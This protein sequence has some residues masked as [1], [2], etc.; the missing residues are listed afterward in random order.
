MPLDIFTE[1]DNCQVCQQFEVKA[2]NLI[3][4]ANHVNSA[5]NQDDV[6]LFSISR[7]PR[8]RRLFTRL[9]DLT[10][11]YHEPNFDRDLK[12]AFYD[13]A[14]EML[15]CRSLLNS[16]HI[17]QPNTMQAGPDFET[18]KAYVECINA[19]PA[20]NY[21]PTPNATRPEDIMFEE[22]P[23]SDIQL[24]IT[25]AFITKSRVIKRYMDRGIINPSKPVVIALN[26]ARVHK[27]SWAD[28]E[29][30]SDNFVLRSLFGM[31]P[32]SMTFDPDNEEPKEF[33][34][35][36]Q[37]ELINRNN[38]VVP[39]DYFLTDAHKHVSGVIYSN[40]QISSDKS[41]EISIVNNPYATVALT[42]SDYPDLHRIFADTTASTLHKTPRSTS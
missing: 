16:N 2:S 9:Y 1:Y 23:E 31:G 17:I 41:E 40:H 36:F 25:N 33:T 13:K 10:K 4:I 5:H 37:P 6:S 30:L 35:S 8:Y 12:L 7:N 20:E 19:A 28:S 39:A 15:T 42:L 26:Y 27:F 18:D 21:V 24:R 22:V 32:Q 11:P 34:V 14:W 29:E 38:S 3:T